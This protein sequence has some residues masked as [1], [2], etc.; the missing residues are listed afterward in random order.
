MFPGSDS[1][2]R[3][4]PG[5]YGNAGE[6]GSWLCTETVIHMCNLEH[7]SIK[8]VH[9][10]TQAA[11]VLGEEG[12]TLVPTKIQ[13]DKNDQDFL[14]AELQK[15]CPRQGQEEGKEEEPMTPYANKVGHRVS[16]T[17]NG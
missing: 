12:D 17:L 16:R 5:E 2:T 14:Q 10:V 6:V 11:A 4:L 9:A 3:K 1:L 7:A 13:A 8:G 15:D